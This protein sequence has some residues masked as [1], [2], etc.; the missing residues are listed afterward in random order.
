MSDKEAE[1]EAKILLAK[2]DYFMRMQA[3][4]KAMEEEFVADIMDALIGE[5]NAEGVS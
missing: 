5:E 2:F 3:T 4:F 1:L